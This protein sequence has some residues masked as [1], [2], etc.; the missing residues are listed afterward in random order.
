MRVL[1]ATKS[2]KTDKPDV[3]CVLLKLSEGDR[4]YLEALKA[5]RMAI[6]TGAQSYRIGSRSLTHADLKLINDEIGRLD[7]STAV[8]FRRAVVVDR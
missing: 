1:L 3:I 8:R 4:E 2:P 7:G 5:A 6:V